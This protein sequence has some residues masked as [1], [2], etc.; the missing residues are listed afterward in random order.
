MPELSIRLLDQ[1]II[2]LG[3]LALVAIGIRCS[4]HSQTDEGYFLA[5]RSMPVWVWC[6][7]LCR[8]NALSALM[9]RWTDAL[10]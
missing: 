8:V 7:S 10:T 4:R 9:T 3:F 6:S 5:G 1:I 2:G